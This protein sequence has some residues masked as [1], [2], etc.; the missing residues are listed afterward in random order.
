MVLQIHQFLPSSLEIVIKK[1]LGRPILSTIYPSLVISFL[2]K[3]RRETKIIVK[4]FNQVAGMIEP[5]PLV[6]T[7]LKLKNKT[8]NLKNNGIL[9]NQVL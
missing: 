1:K 5:L 8:N 6:S 2:I 7:P 9:A 3:I 4:A